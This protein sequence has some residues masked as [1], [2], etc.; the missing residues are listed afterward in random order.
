MNVG[1]R[2][3]V[4]L[5]ALVVSLAA[6]VSAAGERRTMLVHLPDAPIESM[7][8]LGEAVSQLATYVQTAVPD[9]SLEVKAFRKSEDALSFLESQKESVALVVCDPAFLLDL[10][11]GFEVDHR[12]VRRG[13]ET[14]RKI[15]VVKSDSGLT[16]LADLRG[17]SLTVVLSSTAAGS[18]FLTENVFRNEIDANQW[19]SA[20][21][22]ETDD[23][24]AVASLLYGRTDSA[25]ISEDNPLVKSHLGKDL[26][27][28]Y[29]SG[30]ISLSVI[31]V[32]SGALDPSQLEA[33][34]QSL[35]GLGASAEAE[36]I[37]AVLT[38]D[39]FRRVEGSRRIADF[40][41]TASVRRELEVAIPAAVAVEPGALP[42]L[43]PNL[44]PFVVGVELGEV[45]I[46][47]DLVDSVLDG[48][49][50]TPKKTGREP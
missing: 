32:R 17:R 29:A 27:Q 19:F 39:G 20:I 13:K 38:V 22:H 23:F 25:L 14:E 8:R 4:S 35:D 46:P 36:P 37:R 33:L 24:S 34:E 1:L 3:R 50:P 49:T 9:L 15:V 30:P 12:F 10:P 26:T 16:S 45:T 7:G 11:D 44:V 48:K 31:A 28:V 41:Q 2:W 18:R 6:A 40:L 43:A 42:P 5:V 21:T 47:Q